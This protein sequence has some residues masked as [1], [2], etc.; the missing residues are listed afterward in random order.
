M[1]AKTDIVIFGTPATGARA[2]LPPYRARKQLAG[3]TS[4]FVDDKE[5]KSTTAQGLSEVFEAPESMSGFD[6]R[7]A[8]AVF[9]GCAHAGMPRLHYRALEKSAGA[10]QRRGHRVAGLTPLP[11]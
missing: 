8:I 11:L 6:K 1:E 9:A 2:C 7:Y 4:V 10:Y 5:D 3:P